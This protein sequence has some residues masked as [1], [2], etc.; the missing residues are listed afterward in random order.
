[1]DN[2][3]FLEGP[4]QNSLARNNST[5]GTLSARRLNAGTPVRDASREL[6]LDECLQIIKRWKGALILIVCVC[7]F[8][9]LLLAY[10][11]IPIYEARASVEIQKPNENF[12]N[13]NSVSPTDDAAGAN[14]VGGDIQIQTQAKLFESE[15]LLERVAAKLDL[16]KKQYQ[17]QGR[18][19]RAALRRVLGLPEPKQ[20]ST[21]EKILSPAA[22][23]NM[24]VIIDLN[25]RLVEI[26]YDSPD[27]QLSADFVNTLI[28]EY[29][30]LNVES[31]SKTGQQTGESLTSKMEDVRGKLEKSEEE[32]QSYAKASDLLFN[33]SQNNVADEKLR[34]LQEELSKAQADRG[35]TQSKYE[36]IS[37]ASPESLP[38]VLDDQ[39]F[40]EFQVKI[41]DLRRQLAEMSSTLT[42]AHPSV[43]KVRD[44]IASL[45]EARDQERATVVQRIRN[46]FESAQRREH[47]AASNYAGQASLMSEQAAKV[48]HYNNLKNEV[49]TERQMYNSMLQNVQQVGI[50]TAIEPSNIRVVDSAVPPKYPYRPNV[51]LNSGFGVL[52]GAFFGLVFLVIQVRANGSIQ[53]PG[54]T[55]TYLDLPELGAIPAANAE[56]NGYFS[57]YR[58]GKTIGSNQD[59]GSSQ[60][61]L[62]T[63][64]E[65]L[66][67]LADSFRAT[68]TSILYSGEN[69]DRPR[70]IV[71][72]S[73]S[74]REGKTTIASNLGLALAEIGPP[75]LTQPVLLIDGDMHRP[76][77][78]QIFGVPNRWGLSDLLEGKTPPDG[79]EGTFF[80][81]GFKNLCLLPAGSVNLN[82]SPLLHSPRLLEFLNGMRKQFHTIIIDT[83]PLLQ[84]PDARVIGRFA[85]G[86]ILVVRS[87]QTMK[88]SA[89]TVKQ[90]LTE[91]GTRVLGTILNQWDPRKSS[92]YGYSYRDSDYHEVNKG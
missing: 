70:V 56:G 71:I 5:T 75:I 85:D 88:D 79:C 80:Q 73:G 32:L 41:A 51:L 42:P 23:N 11:Q 29:V 47:L 90:R 62:V 65:K 3:P 60:I 8:I 37:K 14:V 4:G 45:E 35:I 7:L 89:L 24:K 22:A 13:G 76:R 77:L 58:N 55:T 44:Q 46:E 66:S 1:M 53:G 20:V 64:N 67:F 78:H 9:S 83:P 74:P 12:L 48:A 72:T 87:A 82:V 61:E 81:T 30:R 40:K 27:P 31:H 63:S 21:R 15:T 16:E 19:R 33:S 34:Q 50:T 69:G 68:L 57:S 28:A 2:Q 36:L 52:S 26:R 92:N 10:S 49:D 17:V 39:A 86:V 18:G 59:E 38:A 6:Y 54:D 25:T 84:I 43:V 91:D